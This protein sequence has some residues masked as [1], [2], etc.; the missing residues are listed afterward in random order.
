MR[1]GDIEAAKAALAATSYD[2]TPV[3]IM[4][5]TDIPALSAFS[6]ITAEKLR[7]I[8]MTVEVQAMDW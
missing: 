2:G 5:P 4:Q 8:G 3:V 1:T 6:L 7:D